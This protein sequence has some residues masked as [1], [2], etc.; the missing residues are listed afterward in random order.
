MVGP[1]AELVSCHA[2]LARAQERLQQLAT[3]IRDWRQP[4]PYR[5]V[6]EEEAGAKNYTE[7]VYRVK[8]LRQPPL[9]WSVTIGEILY[10]VHSALDHL[11]N[12]L[13]ERHGTS[14]QVT[15]PIFKNRAKFWR[16]NKTGSGYVSQSG[17]ARLMLM[18]QDAR[19]L[20]EEV[21][22]YQSGNQ[23]PRHPLWLLHELSNADKHHALHVVGSALVDTRVIPLNRRDAQVEIRSVNFGPF[24][25]GDEIGRVRVWM[26]GPNPD[27]ELRTQFATE[28]ALAETGPAAGRESRDSPPSDHRLRSSGSLCGPFRALLLIPLAVFQRSVAP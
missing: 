19:R 4:D 9:D 22:P 3:A 10:N 12:R 17:A 11:A 5:L 15:F 27:V 16:K 1:P 21:Q 24:N 6:R 28:E 20:I 13:A 25:D 8:V 23:S 2:K 18:P 26:T 14:Q 7:Y